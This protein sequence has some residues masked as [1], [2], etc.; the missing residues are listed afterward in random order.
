MVNNKGKSMIKELTKIL[1]TFLLIS[2]S[3][4]PFTV[5]SFAFG[6]E[7]WYKH[8]TKDYGRT[9]IYRS[10]CGKLRLAVIGQ[11]YKYTKDG[12]QIESVWYYTGSGFVNG[13]NT[14]VAWV[15]TDGVMIRCGDY[16]LDYSPSVKVN[17]KLMKRLGQISMREGKTLVMRYGNIERHLRVINGKLAGSWKIKGI[18]EGDIE[19]K[20]N[21]VGNVK[22]K[23]GRFASDDD[24]EKIPV[25][26]IRELGCPVLVGDSIEFNPD[27][28]PEDT[29]VDG[30]VRQVENDGESWAYMRAAGGNIA[31]DDID[32]NTGIVV[33]ASN[34]ENNNEW[35]IL[36][37]GII[38]FDTSWLPNNAILYDAT[39]SV[40]GSYKNLIG[41]HTPKMQV[42]S[43]SPASNTALV[44]GDFDSLGAIKYLD[45]A[46]AYADYDDSGYNDYVLNQNG[47]D[48][49]DLEGISKFGL[50]E[51]FYDLDGETP[52]WDSPTGWAMWAFAAEKGIG[53]QPK[54]VVI[55]SASLPDA[56]DS[57]ALVQTG[58][59]QV[60]VNW[61][62]S[63]FASW[64]EI[65]I[66][67]NGLPV[68]L[69]GYTTENTTS[70][71]CNITGLDLNST[72]YHVGV[73]AHN[74]FGN[75]GFT[76]GQIGGEDL[77][78]SLPTGFYVLVAGIFFLFFSIFIKK[79]LI[80]LAIIPCM[81]G[82]IV[83]PA[84]KDL[85]FQSGCV[86]IMIWSGIRFYQTLTE[87][88][89]AG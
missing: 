46:Q 18:P 64:Y 53:Y 2:F 62:E 4:L 32:G 28:H 59:S 48:N 14:Y 15:D 86:L 83:E 72:V 29:S 6:D 52:V 67:Y 24:T 50:I 84:F 65:W 51:E 37:R 73:R 63:P 71:A 1:L 34:D 42:V 40:Y 11:L 56:P 13:N 80:Y 12:E 55:Y 38:L 19:I 16:E 74:T 79:P 5:N 33:M 68:N 41:A 89:K 21:Q 60:S 9:E 44:G 88:S 54:L 61:T 22:L 35:D 20:Y 8:E 3:L 25:E 10:A 30:W 36:N 17:G 75:S 26:K 39:L 31:E 70:L 77:E 82:V 43:S 76:S 7:G 47:I 45:T 66:S 87:G 81:V 58:I 23:L 57:L 85:W 49:I 78:I 69:E 27:G